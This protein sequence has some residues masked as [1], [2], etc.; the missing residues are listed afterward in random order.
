MHNSYAI[1]EITHASGKP[2]IYFL[3][4]ALHFESPMNGAGS[5]LIQRVVGVYAGSQTGLLWDAFIYLYKEQ[6]SDFVGRM[7][8]KC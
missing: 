5:F 2:F 6:F 4:S 3:L 7:V 8:L 1:Q